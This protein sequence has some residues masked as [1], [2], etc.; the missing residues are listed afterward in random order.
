L[1][2]VDEMFRAAAHL[3]KWAIG[4]QEIGLVSARDISELVKEHRN[5]RATYSKDVTEV[6]GGARSYIIIAE[7]D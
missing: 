2:K 5:V 4:C 6:A 7:R 1:F 3:K